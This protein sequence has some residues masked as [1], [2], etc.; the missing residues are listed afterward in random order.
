MTQAKLNSDMQALAQPVVLATKPERVP[1]VQRREAILLVA[2]DV[3]LESG[4]EGASMSQIA[5]RLGGSKGTLYSYYESKE[6]LFE[7]LIVE[8]CA[9]RGDAVFDVPA[10]LALPETLHVIAN[11]YVRLVMSDNAIRMLQIV[12]AE[13]R[14][15]PALG[16]LLYESGPAA[17][18]FRLS[19]Q[20]GE[21]GV[22][23]GLFIDNAT[24]AAETFL[25]LCRGSLHLRRMLGLAPE[26]DE[27]TIAAKASSA[28]L[29][30][31]RLYGI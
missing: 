27:A 3:F 8:N 28:V 13:A 15:W 30:F 24:T 11:A 4:Y 6:A 22:S 10:G 2:R 20:L 17:T 25:T 5:V 7:A 14:R 12:A 31:L 9:A 16:A 21:H 19:R 18:I 23:A 29:A 1:S 26:P